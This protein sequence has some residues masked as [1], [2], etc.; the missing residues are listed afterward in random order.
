MD[1]LVGQPNHE[2][3]MS[4]LRMYGIVARM[5]NFDESESYFSNQLLFFPKASN[6]LCPLSGRG[7]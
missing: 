7:C 5:T 1:E 4:Q 2:L 3:D 6:L